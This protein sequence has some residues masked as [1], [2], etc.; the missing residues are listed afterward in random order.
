MIWPKA[1]MRASSGRDLRAQL[2]AERLFGAQLL[3]CY[4]S[5]EAG[6]V[7]M[8]PS[9]L[10]RPGSVTCGYVVP[11]VDTEI[12]DENGDTLATGVVSRRKS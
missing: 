3:I 6:L 12:V 11:W 7:T 5:T 8:A 10:G 1:L 9:T 2:D 4:G